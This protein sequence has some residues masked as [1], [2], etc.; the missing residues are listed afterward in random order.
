MGCD[1]HLFCERRTDF[2]KWKCID[3]FEYSNNSKGINISNIDDIP[4]YFSPI[5]LYSG[6]NY[7]FFTMLAGV[8]N[9]GGVEQLDDKRGL[10]NNLSDMIS[11]FVKYWW[12]DAHSFS[13]YSA[14]ELFKH[15][16]KLSKLEDKTE[17]TEHAYYALSELCNNLLQ[18]IAKEF[19]IY[20]DSD[21]LLEE[22][23]MKYL[24]EVRVVFWFDC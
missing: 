3:Y 24:D 21:E 23:A 13:W 17:E 11:A 20:T 5:P 18:R 19:Y 2:D 6:R 4:K 14:K 16:Y 12:S 22:K 8:R 7:S 10:P 9:S 1:I 15:K